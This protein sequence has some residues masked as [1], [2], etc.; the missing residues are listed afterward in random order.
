MF[1]PARG[2]GKTSSI[3]VK[4]TKIWLFYPKQNFTG[5]D[6]E[7]GWEVKPGVYGVTEHANRKLKGQ[8]S[9]VPEAKVALS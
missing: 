6:P 7:D 8:Q 4:G 5:T 3:V 9:P 2:V 1:D